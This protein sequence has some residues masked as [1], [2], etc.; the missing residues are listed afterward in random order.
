MSKRIS[1]SKGQLQKQ[2]TPAKGVGGFYVNHS[3][4]FGQSISIEFDEWDWRNWSNFIIVGMW[5]DKQKLIT[6]I[7]IYATQFWHNNEFICNNN[8]AG[9]SP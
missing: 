7:K 4:F 9:L 2:Q 1:D 5:F 3:E 6:A 8:R